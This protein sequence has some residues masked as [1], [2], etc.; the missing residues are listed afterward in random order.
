MPL[1]RTAAMA[2]AALFASTGAAWTADAGLCGRPPA[3]IAEFLVKM[4]DPG[5]EAMWRDKTMFMFKDTADDTLYVF[6]IANTSAHPALACSR[7]AKDKPGELETGL[8]CAAPEPVCKSFLDTAMGHMTRI[9]AA[10]K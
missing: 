4:Q 7:P 9:R 8:D 3:P 5:I 2:F 1:F 10:G 6:S